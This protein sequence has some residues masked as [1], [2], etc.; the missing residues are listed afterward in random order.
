MRVSVSTPGVDEISRALVLGARFRSRVTPIRGEA[1]KKRE[2]EENVRASG[3]FFFL[4]WWCVS[5]SV[6]LLPVCFLLP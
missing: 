5:E 3:M 4:F 6:L 1:G 2:R